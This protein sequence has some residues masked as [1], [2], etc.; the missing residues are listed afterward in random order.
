MTPKDNTQ[1]EFDRLFP[2]V[3]DSCRLTVSC[4]R[5]E[6]SASRIARAIEDCDAHILNLNVTLDTDPAGSITVDLRVNRTDIGAICRSLSRYGYDV[7]SAET[8]AANDLDTVR[9][10]VNEMLHYLQL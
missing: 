10:R 4:R 2:A 7:T 6:Y 8:A 5:G 3:D 9:N 1:D